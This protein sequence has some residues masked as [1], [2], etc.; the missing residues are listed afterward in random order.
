MN[1]AVRE[2]SIVDNS[3]PQESQKGNGAAREFESGRGTQV[4]LRL[5]IQELRSGVDS[6]PPAPLI[7]AG[8][9][10]SMLGVFPVLAV[11]GIIGDGQVEPL[12]ILFGLLFGVIFGGGG[13][14][15]LYIGLLNAMD[16]RL[17][18]IAPFFT[19]L[20]QLVWVRANRRT[21]CAAAPNFILALQIL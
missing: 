10:V 17:G 12:G 4:Q 15:A 2:S 1:Q 11:L 18:R 8:L 19:S 5:G 13:G 6:L 9:A 21:F 3:K 16:S 20:L 14:L 7:Y